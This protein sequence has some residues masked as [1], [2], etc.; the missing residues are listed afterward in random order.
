MQLIPGSGHPGGRVQLHAFVIMVDVNQPSQL[1]NHSAPVR[2]VW[3]HLF[4]LGL[5]VTGDQ[6]CRSE[7]KGYQRCSCHSFF[8]IL[9][10][11]KNWGIINIKYPNPN[12]TVIWHFTLCVHPCNPHSGK[13]EHFHYSR[14][15]SHVF[16]I[17]APHQNQPLLQ[18]LSSYVSFILF[19]V[20]YNWNQSIFS[21][22]KY[23]FLLTLCLWE[24]SKF[25][26]ALV[27]I[28]F[29]YCVVFY[30]MNTPQLI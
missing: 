18:R 11:L 22:V 19:C 17:S 25:L 10:F 27:V 16:P 20:W 2:H 15:F 1:L 26:N 5:S 23:F 24:P 12:S 14:R 13:R 29:P 4:P 3:E 8:S 28:S 21:S 9:D 30:C 6:A 7:E